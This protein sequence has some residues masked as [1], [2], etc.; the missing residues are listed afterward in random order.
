[1]DYNR[2]W[3]LSNLFESCY[4]LLETNALTLAKRRRKKKKGKLREHRTPLR[5]MKVTHSEKLQC[6]SLV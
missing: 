5:N 1:M 4:A 3:K 2:H 6:K